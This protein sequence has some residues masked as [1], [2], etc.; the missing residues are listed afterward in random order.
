M[1]SAPP[2]RF[3]RSRLAAA[4]ACALLAL[5]ASPAKAFQFSSGELKGSFDTTLS[6]GGLY[7][8]DDPNPAY[9]GRTS[10]FNGVLGTQNSVNTDDGNVNY[11]K[12]WVSEVF[13]G[14]HDLEL[15]Y[16]N[17]GALVRGYW[18]VDGKSDDTL[19]TPLSDQAKDRVTRG[20]EWL[21]LYARASFDLGADSPLDLRIG[22][23]VLSLGESTFIPNGVNVVNPVD[24]AK[25]RAP[26]SEL[27][28]ALLPVNMVKASLGVTK[29]LTLEPFWLLEFRRNELEP[30]GTYFSTNDFAARGGNMVWLGFGGIADLGSTFGGIPRDK[31]RDGGNFNQFGLDARLLAPQLHDTEFGFYFARYNSRSPLVSARTP[32]G[33]VN[34]D[35]TGPLTIAFVKGGLPAAT[36]AAQAGAIFGLIVKSQTAPATL[37]PTDIA[38]LNSA[39]IQLAIANAKQIALLQAA[40][41]AR[42]FVEYPEGIDL[43]G[44]SFNTS[45][46]KTGI[47]W[48]GEVSFKNN[49]PLQID[50]VELLFAA[51]SSLSRTFST[52]S[53]LNSTQVARNNQLGDY[54][55]L[56]GTEISGYRRHRV[57]TAQTTLTKVFGPTL[58]SQQFT[59]LGEIGGVWVNLPSKDALRYD[60]PGTFTSGDATA[61]LNTG[62]SALGTTPY[63]A[64]ADKFSWG[65]QVLGRLDYNS[66]FAGVNVS[67]TLAF[68]HDV[69][70]NTP[71]PL[72]NF[73]HDRKSINLSVEFTFRNA[74]SL[75][76]RYVNFFGAGRYNL[77]GDRDYFASTVKYSF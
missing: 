7:R 2:L 55:G 64:F 32:T 66:L 10:M 47:S 46:G 21:D 26:G 50:D 18:F 36:A 42:Y 17:F 57:W 3:P 44:A 68:T 13:K 28:E 70:G 59:L 43:L 12:G 25:L 16:R 69:S 31:D 51:L 9:Y 77:L 49:V 62:N 60:S 73:V 37:T 5:L 14:S 27:K 38:T 1:H 54:F 52:T 24:L 76:L 56:Y 33:P 65:Y 39:S 74:W 61:M 8:L 58:G 40:G 4:A 34:P 71:L 35:L 72:G 19:R 29:N 23:Q 30:T 20:A 67:P 53:A 22:R 15:K 11:A 6:I 41:T 48:Q 45:I 63:S 75:E